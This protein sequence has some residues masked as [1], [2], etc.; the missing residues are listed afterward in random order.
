MQ[1]PLGVVAAG[2]VAFDK[3]PLLGYSLRNMYYQTA[4]QID[5]PIVKYWVGVNDSHRM[6]CKNVSRAK[7]IMTKTAV[8]LI[9]YMGLEYFECL[10][11]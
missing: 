2:K 5:V 8:I 3:L 6:C 11:H 4:A 1:Y 7:V 10:T 9:G